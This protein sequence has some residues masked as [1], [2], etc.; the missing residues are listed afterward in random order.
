[1]KRVWYAQSGEDKIA[2]KLFRR[3]GTTN[4]VAVEF[5]ALDGWHNSNTAY[6]RERGWTTYLFDAGPLDPM[7]LEAMIT[8]EN[9]NAVFA[10]AGVPRTFDLLSVDVDGNDLWIW[11]ALT[12][13]P[14]VVIIEHNPRWTRKKARTVPYDP[15]RQW[16]GSIYYGASAAALV[17]LALEKGYALHA[18]TRSNLIFAEAGLASVLK[19]RRVKR[20][21]KF[22]RPD[23]L[24][25]PWVGYP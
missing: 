4:R 25:R 20:I 22:K 15:A 6:F 24:E 9:V 16:D 5:G 7:V 13:R 21:K 18:A 8:A 12:Y 23:E 1:M 3:L 2:A 19:L 10:G 17:A 11:R 14:R